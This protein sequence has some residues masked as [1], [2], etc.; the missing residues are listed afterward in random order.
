M[1][2]IRAMNENANSTCQGWQVF[3]IELLDFCEAS[4]WQPELDSRQLL[5]G[6][7]CGIGVG[8]FSQF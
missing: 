7:S 5:R 4:H 2:Q 6:G 3:A 8:T 1:G